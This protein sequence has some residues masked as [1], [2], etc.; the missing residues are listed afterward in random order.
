MKL[1]LQ[2]YSNYCQAVII[3]SVMTAQNR[4]S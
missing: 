4:T 1:D 2:Q 3:T